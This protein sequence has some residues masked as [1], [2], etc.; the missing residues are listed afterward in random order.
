MLMELRFNLPGAEAYTVEDD[1]DLADAIESEATTVAADA[2]SDELETGSE[3]EREQY[4][5][6]IK[7][8]AAASLT[9]PET[10]YRD[11]TGTTWTLVEI[12][13]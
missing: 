6:V 13:D 7:A 3:Q 2:G 8:Q 11:P 1:E 4:K 9:G 12:E 10:S 5:N